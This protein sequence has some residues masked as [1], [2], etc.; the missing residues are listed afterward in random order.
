MPQIRADFPSAPGSRAACPRRKPRAPSGCSA[1][2]RRSCRKSPVRRAAPCDG[3]PY[4]AMLFPALSPQAAE[5]FPTNDRL[6]G[7]FPNVTNAGS[8]FILPRFRA[9]SA[10][11]T[12][13][14]LLPQ[15]SALPRGRRFA[16]EESGAP[17]TPPPSPAFSLLADHRRPHG[18]T[19]DG[20]PVGVCAGTMQKGRRITPSPLMSSLKSRAFC[21]I[22]SAADNPS[23]PL[24]RASS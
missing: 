4:P 11:A 1:S 24:R 16:S 14:R 10:A 9:F 23:A 17:R 22:S 13:R 21:R 20:N 19:A 15:R 12:S 3:T 7:R 2:C 8:S 5:A 18:G 6:S